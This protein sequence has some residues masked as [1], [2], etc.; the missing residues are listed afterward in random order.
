MSISWLILMPKDHNII[1]RFVHC[2][3][4]HLG[5]KQYGL[6]ERS[7]DFLNAWDQVLNY[8]IDNDIKLLLIAG[9]IFHKKDITPEVLY[10]FEDGL[11]VL[12]DANIN[13][14]VVEGN[15]D[16]RH[17]IN[18]MSWI[19]YL[20]VKGLLQCLSKHVGG[21]YT[22]AWCLVVGMPY[23]GAITKQ[24][25]EELEENIKKD[26]ETKMN[27]MDLPFKI[28]MLHAGVLG[29]IPNTGNIS[30]EDLM[31]FKDYFDYIALGHIHKPYEIENL[32]FNPGGTEHCSLGEWQFDGGFYDVTVYDNGFKS[33]LIPTK[34]RPMIRHTIDV[35]DAKTY[36]VPN[37][38]EDSILEIT[39]VGESDNPPSEQAKLDFQY[40]DIFYQKIVDK[41]TRKGQV[42]VTSGGDREEIERNVINDLTQDQQLTELIIDIKNSTAGSSESL[43]EQ[44][45]KLVDSNASKKVGVEKH[46]E[47]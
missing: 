19:H 40:E 35:N 10:M 6:E 13:V 38:T 42:V 11:E 27:H 33:E 21:I 47:P 46:K 28:L 20:E 43:F 29:Q 1:G 17:T 5:Y 3:D 34:K 41:T 2:A 37:L 16:S 45:E 22:D 24:R 14:I 7:K 18:R 26:I 8:T 15:H 12:R 32:I 25:L 9:D 36:Q 30:P 4:L 23:S 39:L 44:F 31:H